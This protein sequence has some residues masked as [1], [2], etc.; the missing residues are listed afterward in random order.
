[1][2][3]FIPLR[4]QQDSDNASKE[5]IPMRSTDAKPDATLLN[6]ARFLDIV[7]QEIEWVARSGE[8]SLLLM[9][10]VD[11]PASVHDATGWEVVMDGIGQTLRSSVRPQDRVG[12]ID[13]RIL[14]LLIHDCSAEYGLDVAQRLHGLVQGTRHPDGEVMS[15]SIGAAFAPLWVRSEVSVWMSRAFNQLMLALSHGGHRICI[16]SRYLHAMRVKSGATNLADDAEHDLMICAPTAY[17][18]NALRH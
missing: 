1:M 16:D 2:C 13:E 14:G 10:Q 15:A 4:T 9:L 17:P 7:H 3:L 5:T 8:T 11:H 12:L 6:R 18:G